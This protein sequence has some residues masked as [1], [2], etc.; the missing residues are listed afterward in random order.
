M[1]KSQVA[2]W[3]AAFSAYLNQKSTKRQDMWSLWSS[4][5]WGLTVVE[6]RKSEFTRPRCV[7]VPQNSITFRLRLCVLRSISCFFHAAAGSG[8]SALDKD[9][10]LDSCGKFFG[11]RLLFV[12][13]FSFLLTPLGVLP[14]HLFPLNKGLTTMHICRISMDYFGDAALHPYETN[15][16]LF[17][18]RSRFSSWPP[19]FPC[20]MSA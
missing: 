14:Y 19:T 11:N 17:D 3:T 5:F 9:A 2:S 7:Q 20:N 12:C 13:P 18:L 15:F 8:D 16:M 4:E 6:L 10:A 1:A